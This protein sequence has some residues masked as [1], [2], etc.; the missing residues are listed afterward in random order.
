[1][2]TATY[3]DWLGRRH[4]TSTTHFRLGTGAPSTI[5]KHLIFEAT[6]PFLLSAANYQST[7]QG[8]RLAVDAFRHATG[9]TAQIQRNHLATETELSW[10]YSLAD[11]LQFETW[12]ANKAR[13][14]GA[15]QTV[16][17]IDFERL[18]LSQR[19]F[20]TLALN[21][22][23][24]L[25]ATNSPIAATTTQLDHAYNPVYLKMAG[26]F[27]ITR[28]DE[29]DAVPS[30]EIK[31]KPYYLF[32]VNQRLPDHTNIR[33]LSLRLEPP[34]PQVLPEVLHVD[35]TTYHSTTDPDAHL[36]QALRIP[37]GA[38]AL[39][40][41]L[42]QVGTNKNPI[43]ALVELTHQQLQY[44]EGRPADSVLDA[45]ARGYGECTDFADL[46]TSLARTANFPARTIYGLAYKDGQ[47]PV[48][49]F[50]AWNEVYDGEVWRAVDPTW[51]QTQVDATHLKLSNT[52]SARLTHAL[53]TQPLEIQIV[54]VQHF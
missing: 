18:Q 51:N 30:Q 5:S 20:R 47:Q 10:H 50:H 26:I 22:V 8:K 21:E 32:P 46:F 13:Q 38:P 40:T 25:V 31:A 15:S 7:Q 39:I 17:N 45:L 12:L 29:G 35:A 36:N 41:L 27:D 48:F 19:A 52:Q 42:T 49:M 44:T 11:F 37:V 4:F 23:G 24:Y 9:Y 54:D 14:P 3:Q 28:A 1:M 53:N 16:K 33:S 2:T 34:L 6:Q 43:N